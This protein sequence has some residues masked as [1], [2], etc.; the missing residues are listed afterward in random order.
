MTLPKTYPLLKTLVVAGL[1]AAVLAG[2]CTIPIGG[3]G[4]SS[5]SQ[6]ESLKES[7][8]TL[9]ENAR[10]LGQSADSGLKSVNALKSVS[11]FQTMGT[12]TGG[13]YTLTWGDDKQLSRFYGPDMDLSFAFEGFP[14]T[15]RKAT[16]TMAKM[17][18]GTTG[19][20]R[21]EIDAASW[22]TPFSMSDEPYEIAYNRLPDGAIHEASLRVAM[23][24][25]GK[26]SEAVDVTVTASNFQEFEFPVPSIDEDDWGD[27]YRILA[28]Q[29]QRIPTT[30]A[31]QGSVPRMT[32]DQ[33]ITI[34][35]AGSDQV[36]VT[37]SG[38][39]TL[40][41]PKHGRQD[42]TVHVSAHGGTS[43]PAPDVVEV[44]LENVT[45]RYKL[46]GKL[47]PTNE[48]QSTFNGQVVSTVDQQ[49]LATITFDSRQGEKA[50]TITYADGT[51][52]RLSL[53]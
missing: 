16:V 27:A 49:V 25:Q 46:T 8:A 20:V 33:K 41:T 37:W 12:T 11:A 35:K 40:E 43:Q 26:A 18:D 32:F 47:L 42:W 34:Q 45:Q 50:P 53:N 48:T 5:M 3:A 17:P 19:S 38:P 51:S 15:R 30:I 29:I 52:E 6:T 31:W 23:M 2:G 10:S 22:N 36:S 14:G 4:V 7:I 1:G 21:L 44:T 24:P 13:D 9:K 39:M 28:T